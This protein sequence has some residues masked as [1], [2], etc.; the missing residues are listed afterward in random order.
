MFPSLGKGTPE[1]QGPIVFS[2]S[3]DSSATLGRA[4]GDGTEV[5]GSFPSPGP[6]PRALRASSVGPELREQFLLQPVP[7]RPVPDSPGLTRSALQSLQAMPSRALA[8]DPVKESWEGGRMGGG[9]QR[10]WTPLCMQQL[11]GRE[12]P[13]N[14]GTRGKRR[15][16]GLRAGLLVPFAGPAPRRGPGGARVRVGGNGD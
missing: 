6:R 8:Q 3:R 9:A 4:A 2:Q 11:R 10:P 15:D 5:E 1:T 14:K 7:D 12:Y 16:R 13:R